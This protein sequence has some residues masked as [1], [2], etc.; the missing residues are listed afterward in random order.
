MIK[1]DYENYKNLKRGAAITVFLTA[2]KNSIYYFVE[3]TEKYKEV[4]VKANE[5]KIL[6]D[7]G[8]WS[9]DFKVGQGTSIEIQ[10]EEEV[11]EDPIKKY[12][13]NESVKVENIFKQNKVQT[14]ED[15]EWEREARER[16]RQKS[17]SELP[18]K[19]EEAVKSLFKKETVQSV[20]IFSQSSENKDLKEMFVQQSPIQQDDVTK[21]EVKDDGE[22]TDFKTDECLIRVIRC[23]SIYSEKYGI[24]SLPTGLVDVAIIDAPYG[25]AFR[26]NTRKKENRHMA[27]KND[28]NLNFVPEWLRQLD[29]VTKDNSFIYLFFSH[30]YIEVLVAEVKKVFGDGYKLILV[31][32]KDNTTAG[33]LDSWGSQ[34][35]FILFIKKGNKALTEVRDGNVLKFSKVI[36]DNHPTEK[37]L[38][39]I[40][41]LLHNS[42]KPGETVLDTFAGSGVLAEAAL[43]EKVNC[44]VMEYEKKYYKYICHRVSKAINQPSLLKDVFSEGLS[45]RTDKYIKFAEANY[46]QR[47]KEE[48]EK[49]SSNRIEKLKEAILYEIA[50]AHPAVIIALLRLI[51]IEITEQKA[52][53]GNSDPNQN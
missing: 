41:Y 14:D 22:I 13:L 6:A 26:S 3:A 39:L 53:G 19:D 33:D 44:I 31:W 36:S 43:Y 4:L 24:K 34:T 38:D 1:L 42:C 10:F 32:E 40:Q 5:H 29:R 11:Q 8:V 18:L 2:E 49:I 35:E 27:I 47:L 20:D 16:V 52:I 7:K 48:L 45:S 17:N 51:E 50:N 37:P 9:H 25:M 15:A 28:D 30:H 46:N 12:A 21:D 23:D